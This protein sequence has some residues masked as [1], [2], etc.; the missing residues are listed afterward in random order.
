VS[1]GEGSR[2][3]RNREAP[4]PASRPSAR[5]GTAALCRPGRNE[6]DRR[7]HTLRDTS[8]A[9]ETLSFLFPPSPASSSWPPNG[10]LGTLRQPL[11]PARRRSAET[12][13]GPG[14]HKP[15]RPRGEGA[16]PDGAGGGVSGQPA[17]QPVPGS[18]P[19]RGSC[20]ISL[21][22]PK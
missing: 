21:R 5:A 15:H 22:S 9:P 10:G 12:P 13:T 17:L 3:V 6:N 4:Q 16:A 8:S 7:Y 20:C 1:E 14:T 18:P 11:P 2:D 19:P